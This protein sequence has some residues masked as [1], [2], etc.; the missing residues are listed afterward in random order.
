MLFFFSVVK[1][2]YFN[3]VSLTL[4]HLQ[5]V[6]NSAAII[7]ALYCVISQ[8]GLQGKY[9]ENINCYLLLPS[10]CAALQIL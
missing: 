7:S 10:C 8:R 2:L 3:K 5:E 6:Q 1:I 4:A 9:E